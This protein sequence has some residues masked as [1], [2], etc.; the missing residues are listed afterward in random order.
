[1]YLSF[2]CDDEKKGEIIKYENKIID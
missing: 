2:L 1:M